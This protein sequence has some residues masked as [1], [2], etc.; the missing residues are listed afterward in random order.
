MGSRGSGSGKSSGGGT[1]NDE[2]QELL[3]KIDNLPPFLGDD[4]Q[5]KNLVTVAAT[6]DIKET[7]VLYRAKKQDNSLKY[8][9]ETMNIKDLETEQIDLYKENL[10]AIAKTTSGEIAGWSSV[11]NPTSKA[12][13]GIRAIRHNGH[14]IIY[15][16]N[17]RVNIAILQGQKRI[18]LRVAEV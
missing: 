15:D 13:T 2:R 1:K 16:G 11:K 14:T 10:R 18:K 7:K 5:T 4:T 3:A 12:D 17:H 9:N 6:E 8:K